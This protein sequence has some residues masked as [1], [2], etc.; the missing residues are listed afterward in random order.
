MEKINS[1]LI[2]SLSNSVKKEFQSILPKKFEDIILFGSY[3]RGE[4]AE[5]SDIDFLL[6]VNKDL[7]EK[8]KSEVNQFLSKISLQHD[9]VVSCISYRKKD[10]KSR[11]TPFLL[12]VKKEGIVV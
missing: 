7:T 4:Q 12:N 9:L 6:L 2:Q 3:V 8:E 5:G 10:F 1:K 11:N